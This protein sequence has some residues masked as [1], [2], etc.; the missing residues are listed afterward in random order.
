MSRYA[1]LIVCLITFYLNSSAQGNLPSLE[2]INGFKETTTLVVL[3][4]RDVALDAM[5]NESFRKYWTITPYEII[6][7]ERFEKM[8][9][10]SA[11]SFLI[12]T[13]TEFDKDKVETP[14]GFFNLILAH[15]TGD[16]NEMPV[17]AYVPFCG[18]EST[19]SQ[20][21]YKTGMLINA[22]QFQVDQILQNPK[23]IKKQLSAYNRNIPKLKGKTLLISAE[24]LQA[25]MADSSILRKMYKNRIKLCNRG[26]VEKKVI[27]GAENFVALHL[28][29]PKDGS[30][31][32]RCYKML[33]DTKSG[34]IYLKK[35]IRKIR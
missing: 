27:S 14:Y 20:H 17:L 9:T 5:L 16:I 33:I 29:T 22:I 10:N 32:G 2:Q 11:F 25:E 31:D 24:D 19:I 30:I 26:E 35:D 34:V 8:K 6:N 1:I 4:R 23:S 3:D 21:I 15:P 7:I 13:Q 28:V 18:E 12:L